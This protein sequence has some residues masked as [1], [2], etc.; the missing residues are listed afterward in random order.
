MMQDGMP[1]FGL[2]WMLL[3][4]A[5]VVLPFWRICTKAGYS[6][7]LSLLVVIPMVNMVFST[8]SVFQSG[9][10]CPILGAR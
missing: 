6:G 3:F 2:L 7:W 5:I 10:R 4:A 1:G 9:H 8:F